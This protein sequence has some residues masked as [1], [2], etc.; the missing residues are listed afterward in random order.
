MAVVEGICAGRRFSRCSWKW[1][2]RS[3]ILR[4][5]GE[6]AV[7]AFNVVSPLTVLITGALSVAHGD[8]AAV[9]R[10]GSL[11]GAALLTMWNTHGD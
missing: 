7:I 6:S 3:E 11:G 1:V 2:A 5:D 8:S 10:C 4:G 9:Q